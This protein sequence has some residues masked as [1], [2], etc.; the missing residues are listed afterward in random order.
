MGEDNQLS[1]ERKVNK[2]LDA[3]NVS[4]L[5]HV[6]TTIQS[7]QSLEEALTRTVVFLAENW[8]LSR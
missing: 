8:L 3:W 5:S 1:E 4:A 6:S 7:N 2:L